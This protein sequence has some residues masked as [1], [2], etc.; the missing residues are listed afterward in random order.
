MTSGSKVYGIDLGTTF[1][2]ITHVDQSGRPVVI[3]NSESD[4]TTPSVVYFESKEN[5]AVGKSAKAEAVLSP[6][7]VVSAVKRHM[8]DPEWKKVMHGE[9][10]DPIVVSAHILKRLVQDARTITGDEITDVVITCPAYFGVAQKEATKQAGTIAGL[11]VRYVIPEP[12]AAAVAFGMLEVSGDQTILVYD[13]GGGTFDITVLD[14]KEKDISVVC[15]GGDHNLGGKNWDETLS[16]WFF[17]QL[18]RAAGVPEQE[19]KG[20]PET[21]ESVLLEAEKAKIGLSSKEKVRVLLYHDATRAKVELTRETFRELTEG[22]L[23]NTLMLTEDLLHV[24]R[25]KGHSR[26]HKMLLVG[27]STHMPQVRQVLNERF[28]GLEILSFD[29]DEVVAKGAALMGLKCEM[30]DAIGA[31]VERGFGREQAERAVAE[32]LGVSLPTVRDLGRRAIRNVTSKSFGVAITRWRNLAKS[33]LDLVIALDSSGSMMGERQARSREAAKRLVRRVAQHCPTARVAIV[34]FAFRARVRFPLTSVRDERARSRAE[35]AID[36][37]DDGGTNLS[38]GLAASFKELQ[39]ATAGDR[40]QYVIFLTDGEGAYP[41]EVLQSGIA[42]G[43]TVHTVGLGDAADADLLAKVAAAT[44]GSYYPVSDAYKLLYQ[45]LNLIVVDDPIPAHRETRLVTLDDGQMGMT[46]ECIENVERARYELCD[47]D[48]SQVIGEAF[49]TFT[50]PLPAN[51]PV[52]VRFTLSEDGLLTVY[53]KDLTTDQETTA[54][55]KSNA[56]LTADDM[57]RKKRRNATIT[58]TA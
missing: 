1:S 12:T 28:P 3:P 58:V 4:R 14:I 23:E 45:C 5:V 46:F 17:E 15:T 52:V 21:T 49:V 33:G 38:A 39:R 20:N 18:A 2:C 54:V 43:V 32:D 44:G 34:G 19:V 50:R 41:R 40:A 51:S 9:E 7:L 29:P 25:D 36:E 27:G 30:G 56:I 6:E 35:D 10:V 42:A 26:I 31:L 22:L 11:N 13:L 55:L 57:E 37:L 53:G 24:A 16:E 48:R 47:F 8:G